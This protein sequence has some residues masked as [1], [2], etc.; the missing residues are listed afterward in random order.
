VIVPR[1]INIIFASYQ[2]TNNDV[3]IT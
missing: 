2:L 1:L 3:I